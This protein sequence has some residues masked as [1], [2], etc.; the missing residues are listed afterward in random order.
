MPNTSARVTLPNAAS[1]NH[2]MQGQLPMHGQLFS[3]VKNAIASPS[4]QISSLIPL[5]ELYDDKC[6][7]NLNKKI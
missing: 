5:G 7:I 2:A 4:L 6:N 3:K 1:I